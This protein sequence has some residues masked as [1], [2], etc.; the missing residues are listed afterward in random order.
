MTAR[1]DVTGPALW[2]LESERW[3]DGTFGGARRLR[4]TEQPPLLHSNGQPR[5]PD[6]AAAEHLAELA[7]AIGR[8]LTDKE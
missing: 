7:A 3:P 6:P 2:R 4:G 5:R 1:P 8:R